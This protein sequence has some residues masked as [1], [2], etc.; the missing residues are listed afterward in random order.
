[1]YFTL[2]RVK[3]KCRGGGGSEGVGKK[4]KEKEVLAFVT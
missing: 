3:G 2:L 4:K 1:M